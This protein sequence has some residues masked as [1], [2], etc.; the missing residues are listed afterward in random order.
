VVGGDGLVVQIDW[1][2]L[3]GT[4]HS[5]DRIVVESKHGKRVIEAEADVPMPLV[6]K[7]IDGGRG[8]WLLLGWSSY[9]SGMQ[10]EHAWLVVDDKTGPRIANKLEWTSDRSHAGLAVDAKQL[11]IG[12]P[13]PNKTDA[14]HDPD[15]WHL[16]ADDREISLSDVQK[17]RSSPT[18]LDRLPGAYTPPHDTKPTQRGW[19]G[20]FVWYAADGDRFAPVK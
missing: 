19:T 16:T 4:W 13:V 7:V 3:T 12:V 6:E 14:L 2:T 5:A 8:R 18:P 10:T 1:H 9:G 11:R 17:L 15:D 20:R